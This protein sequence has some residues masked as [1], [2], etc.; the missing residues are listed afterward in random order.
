MGGQRWRQIGEAFDRVADAP[1]EQRAMLLNELCGADALL[2]AEVEALL[3]ADAAAT[4]F[5]AGVDSARD[6]A[7]R[8]W[9][10]EAEGESAGRRVGPWRVLREI[11]RG[12]MGVVLLAE[13]ADGQYEQ[14]AA[15][16]LVKRGMDSEAIL[17]RFLRERQIL[18]RLEHPH[19]AR[20]L[21]GGIADDGR[22]YFAM[23]YV[24]GEPLLD[25]CR[26]RGA[27]L[28]Q[29]ITL[30][31]EV[32]AAV[33]FAHSQ[34]V[35]HRDIKPSNI[36]VTS[37]GEARL[38]DF[39]I[40]K[41][42]GQGDG[43]TAT[44][45]WRDRPL[46]PAYAA[47]EQIRGDPV[48]VATDVHGLGCVL[49]E[50][51]AGRRAF[52]I[53]D[54]PTLEELQK[55][56]TATAPRAPSAVVANNAPVPAK[57]LRGDLDTIV[58]K[59]LH[60]DPARR[61]ATVEAFASDLRRYTQ[62]LPISARRDNTAYRVGKFVDRH[63][64]GVF[65][66]TLAILLLLASTVFAFWQ[67]RQK[68]RE[69]RAAQEVT[70]FLSGLF[71]GADPELTQ[72]AKLS[73]QDLLDQGASRLD[74]E[75]DIEP[76][77]RAR[78]LHTIA[79]TYSSLGLYARALPMEEQA[80]ALRRA[81]SGDASLETAE[82]ADELGLIHLRKGE[83]EKAAPLLDEALQTRR[84]NLEKDDP[85]VISSQADVASLL[86]E[87]GDFT[88]ADALYREALAQ[89]GRRFGEE[90]AE[91]AERLDDYAANLENLGKRPQADAA[92][93]R[94]LSI[95]ER[96]FGK[97]SVEVAV[98]L[99]NLGV[100]L[101]AAGEYGAAVEMLER[102]VAIRTRVYG[103][104]HPLTAASMLALS[105]AYDSNNLEKDKSKAERLA[106]QA[107][108]IF[109]RTLPEDHPKI[110]EAL[111][112]LAVLKYSRRDFAGAA[113]LLRDALARSRRKLGDDHP[114][115]LR[116][117]NDLA[118]VISRDHQ[119]AEAER[120]LR[121]ALQRVHADANS[122]PISM[123]EAEQNLAGVLGAQGKTAEAVT[124]MR[125]AAAV[126]AMHEGASANL[127]IA[128]RSLAVAE[129]MDG[130][131]AAAESDLRATL[132]LGEYFS[133]T[134]GID[135]FNWQ[136][137]WADFLVGQHRCVEAMPAI[138]MSWKELEHANSSNAVEKWQAIL[139]KGLCEASAGDAAM[140][141]DGEKLLDEASKK[142]NELPGSD[143]DTY[144]V[145][146]KYLSGKHQTAPQPPAR[147]SSAVER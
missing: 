120:L 138:E 123:V 34:L 68:S 40:A 142:L 19:I 130:Q 87:R 59:A 35:V 73:A 63:R 48:S 144:P 145:A 93:R 99:Q 128:L 105:Q 72:G 21:D 113:D 96:K 52:D 140:K 58:L 134:K 11:G 10:D 137:P 17:A 132:A 124:W 141:R 66:S 4:R 118:A 121:D 47:P 136:M 98:S 112:G 78:L 49:Y 74:A 3:R 24:P 75:A 16:K 139:L 79:H 71:A 53:G 30:F 131:T 57:T 1:P 143:M 12:G 89:S 7:A 109:R 104:G 42:I 13:R 92:F 8:I 29:R 15:L 32:C 76:A 84:A 114:Q 126:R 101:D 110:D 9:H 61:Y 51:L 43:G 70:S 36:L 56:L 80:L 133:A 147:Q 106:E 102:A 119:Y 116:E 111:N 81:Q 108:A 20:L 67:A 90:S 129:E 38:L 62:N 97:D 54:T 64:V 55:L 5:D 115:T 88:G 127:A 26:D 23:E 86:Q 100:H 95:R 122:A 107:L 28:D 117:Q 6:T 60:R 65:V 45:L 31:L 14:Q 37:A 146:A 22:P 83:F 25:W 85:A 44:A 41:A 103:E 77:V 27:K 69:A 94:A 82:S 46:T 18:A 125:K 39:G 91:T 2:R 33:Q 135:H 50:L